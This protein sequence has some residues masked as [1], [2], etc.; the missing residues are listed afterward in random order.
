YRDQEGTIWHRFGLGV[1]FV[2]SDVA[3]HVWQVD[4]GVG[5]WSSSA[6]DATPYY[7][8]LADVWLEGADQLRIF[9]GNIAAGD[10][11][12]AI[13]LVFERFPSGPRGYPEGVEP[14]GPAH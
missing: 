6:G 1:L 3:T 9:V 12:S 8:P 14:A 11:L 5:E 2:A 13:K 7:A 10:Q 4:R